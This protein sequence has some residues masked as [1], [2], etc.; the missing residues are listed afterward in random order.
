[1]AKEGTYRKGVGVV[2]GILLPGSAHFLCGD[3][4]AAVRWLAVLFSAQGATVL[5]LA[6]PGIVS[7]LAGV[8]L[9]LVWLALDLVMLCQSYRPVPRIGFVGWVKVL[10]L[11]FLIGHAVQ[12][13]VGQ[14]V[15]TYK[16]VSGAMQPTLLGERVEP[17]AEGL[18]ERDGLFSRFFAGSRFLEVKAPADG[19][20]S[21]PEP[22]EGN[23]MRLA[24]SVGD[25]SFLLPYAAKPQKRAGEAVKAGET[26]WR[27]RLLAGDWMF[28]ER[29]TYRFAE[30]K[31]GDLVAFRTTGIAA[32]DQNSCYFKRVVGMPGE[33]IK[34][35]PPFLIVDGR[36][37]TEPS[38]F[39]VIAS[40]RNGYHG[41][42]LAQG[43]TFLALPTD[44]VTL[45]PDE[46]FMLGDNTRNSFD[47]RYWGPVRRRNIVGKVTRVYWPFTR[48][49]ALESER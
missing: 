24:Y 23:V 49:N 48:I 37:V 18:G 36:K 32:L 17:L 29:L 47:S 6:R 16:V 33:R 5:T 3:R 31:R 22:A 38:I 42:Q 12:M 20:M 10:V 4:K 34:I 25:A 7:Y 2:F 1:M 26:L 30:P 11:A 13:T 39:R 43:G 41:F 9:G 45:G 21:R 19:V 15:C 14:A 40:G 8:C 28:V 44:E 27:G 35:E 46:Y